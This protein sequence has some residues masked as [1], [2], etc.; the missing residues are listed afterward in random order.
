[1]QIAIKAV[2]CVSLL[3]VSGSCSSSVARQEKEVSSTITKTK[4]G[5]T[6][7]TQDI[8]INA[9][10]KDV[11]AAFTT[12]AGWIRWSAPVAEIDLKVGGTIKSHYTANAKI[13]DEGTITL[14]ILNYVPERLLTIRAELQDNWP[15]VMK[16]DHEKLMN[17]LVF[18]KV[19]EN[20][21]H[22]ISY[23]LG[24]GDAPIYQKLLKFFG[25]ANEGL[26]KKLKAVLEKDAGKKAKNK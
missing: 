25:P 7:L 16:V 24:Y 20:R 5:E 18:E 12:G 23:G 19:N 8:W 22:V 21:T 3:F 4:A 1:V 14:H 2:V 26:Y 15:E 17:V 13:G 10:V 6:I 11:W 9:P